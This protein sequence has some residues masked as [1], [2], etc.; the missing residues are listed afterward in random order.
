MLQV[1]VNR[2]TSKCIFKKPADKVALLSIIYEEWND[3]EDSR[4]EKESF[5][6]E[7]RSPSFTG[8]LQRQHNRTRTANATTF[9]HEHY[10]RSISI[11][12]FHNVFMKTCF[13]FSFGDCLLIFSSFV[14]KLNIWYIAPKTISKV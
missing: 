4:I 3:L 5:K 10:S 14:H 2:D 11:L 6:F 9:L 13:G 1:K 12:S 8:A 7:N